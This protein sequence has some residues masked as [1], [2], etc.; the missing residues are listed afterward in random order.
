M[1]LLVFSGFLIRNWT[2]ELVTE[3]KLP[4]RKCNEQ[5]NKV[6]P[7]GNNP[8][9]RRVWELPGSKLDTDQCFE[10]DYCNDKPGLSA[11]TF[12][13]TISKVLVRFADS[14]RS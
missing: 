4:K 11:K 9:W 1:R 2:K 12:A 14:N 13:F 6:F 10:G 3:P 7:K 5:S 8:R